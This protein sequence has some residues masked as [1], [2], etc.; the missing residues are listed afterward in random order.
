MMKNLVVWKR[1]KETGALEGYKYIN[2]KLIKVGS[3]LAMKVRNEHNKKEIKPL[4][5]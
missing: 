1:N 4:S 3:V 2:G 5:A